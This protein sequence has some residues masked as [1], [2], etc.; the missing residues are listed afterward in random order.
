MKE[1]K[2]KKEILINKY[3]YTRDYTISLTQNLTAED[4]IIQSESFVSPT[5][6]H[7]AHTTWFFEKFIIEKFKKKFRPFNK[8]YN[9]LFNSYYNLV[10]TQFP[11]KTRGQ[12]SRPPIEE[13][14]K[15]RKLVDEQINNICQTRILTNEDF[16]QLMNIGINHEQQHQELILMDIL[17]VFFHNPLKPQYTKKR[18]KFNVVN[19]Q[20]ESW[21]TY[22]Q[23]INTKIGSEN[24]SFCFDN[25]LPV[26]KKVLKP[27]EINK[28][29]VNNL[30]WKEFINDNGYNRPELW[31]SDGYSYIKENSI[32]KPLYWLDEDIMFSLNGL[33]KINDLDPVCHISFYEADAFA[34]WKKKKLPS[35]FE[36]EFLLKSQ[37]CK[38]N[39]L[40]EKNYE[41]LFSKYSDQKINQIYGD[42]WEWTRSNYLPY[43]GFTSWKGPAGEYNGKFMCNQ[44]V[45]KGGSCITPK[46]HIRSS[47]RNFFYP[48]D[49]WQFS[50]LRLSN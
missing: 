23:P 24:N 50:G 35:E 39:F 44:F 33:K 8:S 22:K 30:Q 9:F 4:M 13:I 21:E 27:F 1:L 3:N 37:K 41:P 43:D 47:Y 15:Y 17:N 38:G 40:E 10:G 49:R 46:S 28:N 36:L 6:W 16:I 18:T 31:L 20:S 48:H 5:K 32:S 2:N 19:R 29:L 14:F 26:N 7:L 45:L 12:L 25:E 34:R 11:Q 42:V